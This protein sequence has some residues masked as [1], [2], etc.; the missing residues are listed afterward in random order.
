MARRI[1]KGKR[2]KD[3]RRRQPIRD[4]YDT[5][6]I[7]CEGNKTEPNYFRSLCR[8]LKL[9]TANIKVVD[10]EYGTD[11]LSVVNY[12]IDEYK[13]DPLYDHVYCVI[14][15]DRHA[16]FDQA[17]DLLHRTR[18]RNNGQIH[19]S[20][21]IPCFEYWLLLHFEY[22]TR[23]FNAPNGQSICNTVQD[24]LKK[25]IANYDK[26][27]DI[28]PVISDKIET[29]ITNSR[30]VTVEMQ[31]NASDN[32]STNLHELVSHLLNIKKL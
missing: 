1:R 3:L 6:L 12:A 30:R 5:V 24:M 25:H 26:G 16:T 18:L 10:S 7:V 22:T 8:E 9:N 23:P 31:Q 15:R 21:S 13:K 28:H 17:I 4:D 19:G 29:A 11:P 14:D 27:M 32:P 2:I 20:I